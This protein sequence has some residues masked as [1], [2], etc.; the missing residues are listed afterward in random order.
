MTGPVE[1]ARYRTVGIPESGRS[2]PVDP[3]LGDHNSGNFRQV[4]GPPRRVTRSITVVTRRWR[5]NPPEV[6]L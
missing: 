1:L 3:G 2:W 5:R 6:I 4:A